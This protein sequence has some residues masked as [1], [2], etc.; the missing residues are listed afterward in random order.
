MFMKHLL[1]TAAVC[2]AAVVPFV[3]RADTPESG[4]I[5]SD[6]RWSSGNYI[7]T[8]DVTVNNNA[9]LTIDPGVT[10]KFDSAKTL[11]IASTG[12]L[13]AEGT[14][15]N[16]I[17]FT[18]DTASPT[19]GYWDKIEIDSSA[20]G[21]I[22]NATVLYGGYNGYGGF[23]VNSG[24]LTLDAV[25]VSSIQYYAI[26]LPGGT[27]R[28]LDNSAV[29]GSAP[30]YEGIWQSGG[31]LTVASSSLYDNRYGVNAGGSG[32]LTLTNDS[33]ANTDYSAVVNLNNGLVFTHSGNTESGGSEIHGFVVYSTT[34]SA[35]QTFS[36]N[37][38]PYIISSTYGN[39]TV[40]TN[41]TFTFQPGAVV[42]FSTSSS[43]IVVNGSL[44]AQG[45][46]ASPVYFTS[47][48][49]SDADGINSANTSQLPSKGNW[50]TIDIN[51]GGSSTF[52]NAIVRYGGYSGGS[53]ETDFDNEGG[54]LTVS[55]TEIATS[56]YFGIYQSS[57][58]LNV[59]SSDIHSNGAY[60]FDIAGGNAT[61]TSSK[62]HNNTTYG[63]YIT[64]GTNTIATTAIH[65]NAYGIYDGGGDTTVSQ[66]DIY[67][68]TYGVWV[69]HSS[70]DI[71]L[72][73]SV[74]QGNTSDGVYNNTGDLLLSTP[75]EDNWWASWDGPS[76]VGPGS[77]DQV[78]SHV[79]YDPWHHV[80]AWW[81]VRSTGLNWYGSTQYSDEWNAATSTWSDTT[82]GVGLVSINHASSTSQ[83]S[84]IV[85]D[86]PD[87]NP[88][89]HDWPAWTT[90]TSAP[91]VTDTL[92]FSIP[93]MT[94]M[95]SSTC[96]GSAYSVCK[97]H[98]AI[99][100]LG[101]ALGLAHSDPVTGDVMYSIVNS[102]HDQTTL[103]SEDKSDYK[104][105]WSSI[106]WDIP[107]AWLWYV[108]VNP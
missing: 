31:D 88:D 17:L 45:T 84:L 106:Y 43:K 23:Y 16:T 105:L 108:L 6:T 37:D 76:G 55:S 2:A 59:G 47:V 13:I 48:Y 42:K 72:S 39:F 107:N 102:S 7:V 89:H 100:E 21:T 10:V 98:V 67:S 52:T 34:A 86:S 22:S 83:A 5:S 103:G 33:F 14:A 75:A 53:S 46:G 36:G 69:Q 24:T 96:T 74:I 62:V 18:A 26:W 3:S 1:I 44:L 56:V 71:G 65:D 32:S 30:S 85:M 93:A 11:K 81:S 78:T 94:D 41:R 4:T 79:N 54:V 60:G 101:H 104:F 28:I 61:V 29:H 68:N 27:L 95:A 51:S 49:D 90:V 77:G 87:Y 97:K 38:L 73:E 64:A 63:A 15:T 25:E 82:N 80:N 8:G 92:V 57:G 50:D 35:D 99:H 20:S 58:T 12:H 91:T 70:L 19:K 9:T 66:S 40:P